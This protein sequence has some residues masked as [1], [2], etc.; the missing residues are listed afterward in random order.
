VTDTKKP[1]ICCVDD[2]PDNLDILETLLKSRGYRTVKASEGQQALEIIKNTKPDLILLDVKMPKMDGYEACSRLQSDQE[3]SYIPVIF[4]TALAEGQDRAKALALGAADYLTKPIQ[5]K[6]LFET[7]EKH[8]KTHDRWKELRQT[9]PTKAPEIQ[10]S[11][12]LDFKTALKKRLNL[13]AEQQK[14]LSSLI[15]QQLYNQTIHLGLSST[16]VAKLAAQ[17]LELPYLSYVNPLDVSLGVLP[18][19]FCKANLIIAIKKSGKQAFVCSNPFNM[20]LINLLERWKGRAQDTEILVTEPENI[21]TLFQDAP[22]ASV[23]AESEPEADLNELLSEWNLETQ[24][25]EQSEEPT[26]KSGPIIMLANQIIEQAYEMRAS[27]IHIEPQEKEIVIRYRIDG[28]LR[29][30]NRLPQKGLSRPLVSRLKIMSQMDIGERRMPQDGRIVFKN[31]SNKG[32]NFDLRVATAPMNFGEKVVLRILDKRKSVLPLSDLGFTPRNLDIY[33]KNILTPYGMILHVGPTGSGKSM[34]LYSALN[35]VKRPDLNIQTIEDPIEYTLPGINQLEVNQVIN[36]T[37]QRA[38]RSYLRQDPDIILVGEIRDSE[39][40]EISVSAALTGHLLLSTLHTNDASASLVRLIDM[41]IEPFMVSSSI[42]LVCAQRLLRRLCSKCKEPFEPNDSEKELI[43]LP[44][45][46]KI[47][48]Y[49]AKGCEACN[50]IGYTGRI[51][52]H[53]M[54][55]PNEALRKLI[56]REGTPSEELQRQA[57]EDCGMTTLYWDAMEKVRAGICSIEEVL[58]NVRK[59]EFDSRP[60]W[61]LEELGLSRQ[62]PM[63]REKK[64]S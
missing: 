18:Q 29:T 64:A 12:F 24:E 10:L 60:D 17:F 28:A 61:M 37:F 58:S 7:I 4:L 31:F 30:V 32:S 38:L 56:N 40:A 55:V 15:P 22:E 44:P 63:T 21:L 53:E 47:T 13:S 23:P 26:E 1:L 43:G 27:D 14:I 19:P 25:A 54:L 48:L 62:G 6:Q 34:T 46:A 2:V 5:K 50:D 33:K 8:T 49:R 52:I 9:Q 41:G 35:E 3:L 39:T 20:E 36:L 16:Q 59:D 57:V 45:D 11:D 42:V 51:G